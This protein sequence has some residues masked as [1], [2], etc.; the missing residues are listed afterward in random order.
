MIR[1]AKEDLGGGSAICTHS[2]TRPGAPFGAMGG[3]S[4]RRCKLD[5]VK[6]ILLP[7]H[8]FVTILTL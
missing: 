7:R 5:S 8:I 4:G 6:Q 1:A 3:T 2:A